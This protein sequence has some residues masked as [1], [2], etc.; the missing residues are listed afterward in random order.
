V[1]AST[2]SGAVAALLAAATAIAV[3]DRA[4]AAQGNQR[5]AGAVDVLAGE[6]DE[7]STEGDWEPVGE[8]VADENAELESS[9]VGLAVYSGTHR[10]AGHVWVP[11]T[12]PGTCALRGPLGRRLRACARPYQGYTLVAAAAA[13]TP[14][15]PALY[16]TASVAALLVGAAI[17]AGLS[18]A[19]AR[20]AL[21]PIEELTRR[22]R[23]LEPGAQT[24]VNLGA[25]STCEEAELI[26]EA[27]GRLLDRVEAL[28]GQA[29]RFSADAAHELRTPLAAIR[30]ELELALE[31]DDPA[32]ARDAL[33][34]TVTRIDR[35][36]ELVE[37][38]LVLAAPLERAAL[39]GEAVSLAE[40]LE[41]LVVE[42]PAADRDRIALRLDG[43]GLVRGD[44]VLLRSMLANAI[45]NALKF[46]ASAPVAVRLE[47]AG[48]AGP[49]GAPSVQVT[50]V[51]HGPGIPE[52]Q[53]ER[54]FEPFYRVRSDATPGHGLGLPLI[55]HLARAHG[56][57][58]TFMDHPGGAC[59]RLTLPVWSA[60]PAG[61]EAE[62]RLNR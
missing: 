22:L 37:R 11:L 27:L 60:H 30:A 10:I 59:L 20:W 3:V 36:H 39:E 6:L 33:G 1:V 7:G 23:A 57:T 51:D 8:I 44:P 25:A 55:S 43:E 53:R 16:L 38:L 47:E 26:R 40:L 28:L 42:L 48:G 13:D 29:R 54:V 5:L 4:L 31:Q 61:A 17:G 35:L 2:S 18:A 56:G 49:D 21:R 9:G 46:S 32:A 62:R 50:V 14:I 45:G 34:H 58:A 24:A 19:L 52:D 12:Q 15:L 41:E